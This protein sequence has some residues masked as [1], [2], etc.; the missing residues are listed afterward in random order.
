MD[1]FLIADFLGKPVWMWLGF[2]AIVV[3]LLAFDLGILHRKAK[4]IEVGESLIL[5]AVYIGLGVAF[6]AWVWWY[7]GPKAGL[8]I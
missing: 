8:N 7:I 3:A 6:G 5:S 4:E 1:A 2:V